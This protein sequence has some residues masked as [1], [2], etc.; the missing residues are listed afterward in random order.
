MPNRRQSF[1]NCDRHVACRLR[2]CSILATPASSSENADAPETKWLLLGPCSWIL[3]IADC[4]VDW[5]SLGSLFHS[6][7]AY[8]HLLALPPKRYGTFRTRQEDTQLLNPV[9]MDRIVLLVPFLKLPQ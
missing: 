4:C 5:M 7:L 8:T 9:W 3:C 1:L 6:P 2:P